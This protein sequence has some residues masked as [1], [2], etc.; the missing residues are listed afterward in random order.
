MGA[1][2]GMDAFLPTAPTPPLTCSISA[3]SSGTYSALAISACIC[4]CGV[5]PA[6]KGMATSPL[7]PAGT[8]VAAE[9]AAPPP[10]LT[11]VGG[12]A[13]AALLLPFPCEDEDGRM[14]SGGATG[15]AAAAAGRGGRGDALLP[16]AV[17]RLT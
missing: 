10:E 12:A 1:R 3:E 4:C 8:A 11:G 5:V 13:V 9:L 7:P 14:G 16:M 6:G 15:A 17:R 2:R